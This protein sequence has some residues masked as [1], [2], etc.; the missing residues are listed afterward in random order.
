MT[1]HCISTAVTKQCMQ[2]CMTD[3]VASAADKKST[4]TAAYAATD[5]A[6]NQYTVTQRGWLAHCLAAAAP[7][8]SHTSTGY[9]Y[10]FT[11]VLS[12]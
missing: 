10:M 9:K 1:D 12:I 2:V 11:S 5:Q 3:L 7:R 4:G 6:V 8:R